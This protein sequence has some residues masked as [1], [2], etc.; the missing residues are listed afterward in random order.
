MPL[1]GTLSPEDDVTHRELA[2]RKP[3][4]GHDRTSRHSTK[5]QDSGKSR[6]VPRH[7]ISSGFNLQGGLSLLCLTAH[8]GAAAV[9]NW[10]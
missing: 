7:V 1:T 8:R 4:G 3:P 5:C 6:S 10:S 2:T 9:E